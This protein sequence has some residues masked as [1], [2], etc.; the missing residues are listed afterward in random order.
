[1]SE[2]PRGSGRLIIDADESLT[3][4]D[5]P[6]ATAGGSD[7]IDNGHNLPSGMLFSKLNSRR[8]AA[9][10]KGNLFSEAGSDFQT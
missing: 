8:H 1:V 5:Q 7:W 6:P 9:T 3:F 2:P 4:S 10:P